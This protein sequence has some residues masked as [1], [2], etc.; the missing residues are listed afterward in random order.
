[1]THDR[2]TFGRSIMQNSPLCTAVMQL[3]T[4]K[5]PR[6]AAGRRGYQG[7]FTPLTSHQSLGHSPTRYPDCMFMH[8]RHLG[9]HSHLPRTG[10]AWWRGMDSTS[11]DA[12]QAI[13]GADGMICVPTGAG[14]QRRSGPGSRRHSPAPGAFRRALHDGQISVLAGHESAFVHVPSQDPVEDHSAGQGGL[15]VHVRMR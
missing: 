4:E 6:T 8:R 9:E 7:K 10:R 13:G 2:R 12:G 5:A 15:P 11:V 1:M 14:R 3:L